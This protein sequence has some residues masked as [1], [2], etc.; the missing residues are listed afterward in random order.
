MESN[1]YPFAKY[2]KFLQKI[3][4]IEMD[5]LDS[6][7]IEEPKK[8]LEKPL[9]HNSYLES[10]GYLIVW[11]CGCF[12]IM[13]L[14]GGFFLASFILLIIAISSYYIIN[15]SDKR[16]FE[17]LDHNIKLQI[18]YEKDLAEYQK[19]IN[20]LNSINS[21]PDKLREFHR[22]KKME[23]FKNIADPIEIESKKGS[24]EKFFFDYI[25]SNSPMEKKG[26]LVLQNRGIQT[27]AWN[28]SKYPYSCDIL[29][30]DPFYKFTLNVEIDEPYTLDEK[31]PIHFVEKDN[32]NE[33][34]D[35]KDYFRDSDFSE[36]FNWPVLR[37]AE[38][39]VVRW[40]EICLYTIHDFI[41]VMINKRGLFE[42]SELDIPEDFFKE[43][44]TEDEAKNMAEI[45]YRMEYLK[46]II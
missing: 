26:F 37:F 28:R 12:G 4:K 15:E 18:Q 35:Y 7:L 30:I 31:L 21:N 9:V 39:Q 22:S 36:D 14:F 10:F 8:P 38:E 19:N 40:P 23:I 1:Y 2:S 29:I 43:R 34:Y 25:K 33:I 45:N 27:P 5:D 6:I 13:V 42:L 17:I 3:D 20:L 44:W 16:R 41:E 32:E 11:L 24:S 46:K